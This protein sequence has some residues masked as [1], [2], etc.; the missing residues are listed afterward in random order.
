MTTIVSYNILAGGY[1]FR[2]NEARRTKQLAAIIRSAHPDIV[3]LVEA[4]HPLMQQKPLVIEELASLL[5][6]QLIMGATAL[7][8]YQLALLTHLPVIRTQIH[9]HANLRRPLLEVC[10]EEANGQQVKVFVTHLSA[11]FNEG[12]GGGGIRIRE[13][14]AILDILAPFRAQGIPHVLIGDFNSLAPGDS[15]QASALVNYV[16]DIEKQHDAQ[17]SDGHPYLNGVVPPALRFLNPVLRQIPRNPFFSTPF[18]AAASLY[19]PRGAIRLLLEAGYVDCYRRIHPTAHGFTCPAAAP[20]G[21]ID[22]IF[23]SPEMAKYLETCYVLLDGEGV[24]GSAASD[25][26]ALGSE[27]SLGVRPRT[28]P[29][30]TPPPEKI[31][32]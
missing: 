2:K 30:P 17:K 22:F 11:S 21:R 28:N 7:Y 20:A 13:V 25:H 15:F 8:N 16:L 29:A 26:L 18:N 9:A 27:F 10:V 19:A 32:T 4:T 23:A 14:G 6:M 31:I 3:G 24:P 5:N 12:R 1:D